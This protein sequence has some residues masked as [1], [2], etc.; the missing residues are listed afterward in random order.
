MFSRVSFVQLFVTLW[1]ITRRAPLSMGFSR[2]VSGMGCHA[3]LQG[4][5]SIQGHVS[6]VPCI[7]GALQ[8][9][10]T[11]PS[12]K[13]LDHYQS[14]QLAKNYKSHLKYMLLIPGIPIFI[15]D[16]RLNNSIYFKNIYLIP[17]LFKNIFL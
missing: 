2:K 4:I 16:C 12:W 7:T 8:W 6:C 10:P 1:T 3:L 15:L 13:P 5:F 9:I 14:S 17:A 11:E